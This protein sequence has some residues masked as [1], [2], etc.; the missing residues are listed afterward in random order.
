ML[1]TVLL[2]LLGFP[3]VFLLDAAALAAADHAVY[4]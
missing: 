1:P 3:A 4:V 2:L